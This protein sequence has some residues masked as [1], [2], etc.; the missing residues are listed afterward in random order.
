MDVTR[1]LLR[2]A[3]P[4][5]FVV[6]ASGSTA[7]RFAVER[8]LRRRGWGEALT[9]ANADIL[10]VCGSGENR[11]NGVVDR[12]WDQIPSPRVLVRVAMP[13]AVARQLDEARTEMWGL[14]GLR[15]DAA[16]SIGAGVRGMDPDG[17][18]WSSTVQPHE[19]VDAHTTGHDMDNHDVAGMGDMDMSLEMPGGISMADRGR[20]RDGLKLDQLHV[21]LGPALSAW[22][23]GLIVRLV[24]Q[25][26][27]VQAAEPEVVGDWARSSFW[28]DAGADDQQRVRAAAA[29]DSLQRFL[30]VAGWESA[31]DT[32]RWLRDQLLESAPGAAVHPRFVRW[33]RRVRGSRVLRWS[34]SGLGQVGSGAPGS[35]RG[36]VWARCVRWVEEIAAVIEDPVA[37]GQ[38]AA[39]AWGVQRAEHARAV[40]SMLPLV[41]A[42]QEFAAARLI[43]ASFDPDLE[44]LHARSLGGSHG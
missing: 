34:M 38:S 16:A 6:G 19:N 4:R 12:L 43:V 5:A 29:A 30:S 9:P 21:A 36:D 23:S 2:L 42:G 33:I 27:V 35:L 32:G 37:N 10:V 14:A 8:E 31:A 18:D 44:A 28:F 7:V 13:D 40:L 41:L 22:P 26:D 15:A 39:G 17:M 3:I 24:V 11:F 1:R 20:D 25:G